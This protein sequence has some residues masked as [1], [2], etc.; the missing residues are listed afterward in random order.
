MGARRISHQGPGRAAPSAAGAGTV[1]GDAEWESRT[2]S[3]LN[4]DLVEDL[5]VRFGIEEPLL[6]AFAATKRHEFVD[7]V[8]VRPPEDAI[9]AGDDLGW[10]ELTR[11]DG[12]R[13]MDRVYSDIPLVTEISPDGI[14]LS[15]STSPWLMALMLAELGCA[16]SSR[17]VEIGTGT[18]YNAAVLSKMLSAPDGHLVTFE[19]NAALAATA[20]TRLPSPKV[21]VVSGELT[22]GRL[23]SGSADRLI[24]TVG[25][26][27]LPYAW[28]DVLHPDGR[29][30]VSWQ[31]RLFSG[32]LK[33]TKSA[34]GLL[35]GGCFGAL[36]A[37][38]VP[39]TGSVGNGSSAKHL[40]TEASLW[41][42]VRSL[43]ECQQ[44]DGCEQV[45]AELTEVLQENCSGYALMLA[46]A[47]PAWNVQ[48]LRV[49]PGTLA[50]GPPR[51]VPEGR[52]E[53][54]LTDLST[55]RAASLTYEETSD[56]WQL[57]GDEHLRAE[58]LELYRRWVD[59]GRPDPR[60]FRLE[61]TVEHTTAVPLGDP[62]LRFVGPSAL[63]APVT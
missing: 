55:G 21:E 33:L 29:M 30:V 61:I 45:A 39:M 57:A 31:P 23:G 36:R 10:T 6:S 8:L 12:V 35:S 15:S 9:I 25:A 7:R 38:F 42:A 11:A 53:I 14:P 32:L 54:L 28:Y 47:H 34:D 1:T 41:D 26:G 13:W 62:G 24:A 44:S 19:V 50:E 51:M 46:V 43:R 5:R 60:G 20:R 3:A 59:L 37:G 58:C 49:V 18:G 16:P 52:P 22:L 63:A 48:S 17:V 27:E 56:A 4:A 2:A 40:P